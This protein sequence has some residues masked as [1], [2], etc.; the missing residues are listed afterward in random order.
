MYLWISLMKWSMKKCKKKVLHRK[1]CNVDFNFFIFY[2]V[3]SCKLFFSLHHV[4]WIKRNLFTKRIILLTSFSWLLEN[5]FSFLFVCALFI[6]EMTPYFV[7]NMTK[8][9]PFLNQKKLS[10]MFKFI[11]FIIHK[12]TFPTT[13]FL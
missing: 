1:N 7:I 4:H 5:F 11:V 9:S 6:A 8:H 13:I 12:G 10:V 2:S 3:Q